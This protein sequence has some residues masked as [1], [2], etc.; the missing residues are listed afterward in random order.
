MNGCQAYLLNFH[1]ITAL[2]IKKKCFDLFADEKNSFILH[3]G[4]ENM[5]STRVMKT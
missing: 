3:K 1:C 4:P 2:A 5:N